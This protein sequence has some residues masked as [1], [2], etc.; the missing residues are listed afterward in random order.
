M[1]AAPKSGSGKTLITCALLQALKEDGFQLSS[2]KCGPDYIDPMFHRSVLGIPS[3]NLDSWFTPDPDVL[4]G[5][6]RRESPETVSSDKVSSET[7]PEETADHPALTV[8]EGVMGLYDGLGGVTSE[9]SCYDTA[10]RTGTPVILVVDVRGM[11]CSVN[12]LLSGFLRY[13]TAHLIRGVI[14]NR[15]SEGYFGPLKECIEKELGVPVLGWFPKLD[16]DIFTSRHLG[17]V[18]PDE[19][20]AL[21]KKLHDAAEILRKTV[22]LPAVLAAAETARVCPAA[23]SS[24]RKDTAV[25]VRIAVARDEAFC[26]YYRENLEML[27]TMG[28]QLLYFSPL[29]DRCLPEGTQGLLLGGGYP[30]LYLGELCGNEEMKNS[31]RQAVADGLPSLAECGGFMYLHEEMEDREGKAFPAVGLLP[32]RAVWKNHAVRFGYLELLNRAEMEKDAGRSCILP[33][34]E[35]IRGHEFHYYDCTENGTALHACKPVS[36]KEWDCCFAGEDHLWGFPHLYYPSNPHVAQNFIRA[37]R[38]R[39]P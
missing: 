20:P 9:G 35:T 5:I 23:L 3:G 34:G 4:N 21:Q 39:K 38:R 25:P 27:Q 29:H 18:M 33:A 10:V 30:E 19:T 7:A 11:G 6:L 36:G 12:A 13:D 8:L 1:I 26:F 28:A 24:E 2:F 16:G 31:I 15:A 14:L 22:S 17:L 32:G 37:A